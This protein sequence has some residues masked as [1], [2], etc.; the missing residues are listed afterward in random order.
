MFPPPGMYPSCSLF[1]RFE[2]S[3][4][5]PGDAPWNAQ[6]GAVAHPRRE[7]HPGGHIF[8]LLEVARLHGAVIPPL[9]AMDVLEKLDGSRLALEKS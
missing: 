1:A 8:P 9:P 2:S 5:L 4:Q 7:R 6:D 3:P